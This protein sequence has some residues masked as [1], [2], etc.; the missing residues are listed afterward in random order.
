MENVIKNAEDIYKLRNK[1]INEIEK[2][3]DTKEAEETKDDINFGWLYGSK[4]N[5]EK[6]EKLVSDLK[7][8][9]ITIDGEY[10]AEIYPS[11]LTKILKDILDGEIDNKDD[12]EKTYFKKLSKDHNNLL[13]YYNMN[14]SDTNI[15]KR[16]SYINTFFSMVFGSKFLELIKRDPESEKLDIATG[17]TE[18]IGDP[19]PLEDEK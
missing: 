4:N 18:D 2:T 11:R 14:K 19:P 7:Q 8:F 17:G 6:L 5:L 1:I 9:N 13:K 12:V 10:V 16:L 15:S 3:E